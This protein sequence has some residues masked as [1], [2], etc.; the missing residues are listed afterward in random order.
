MMINWKITLKGN[1]ILKKGIITS[2]MKHLKI[3]MKLN[4]K[5][6]TNKKDKKKL[7]KRGKMKK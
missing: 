6:T 1:W 7:F 3:K 2:F 5:I 4:C